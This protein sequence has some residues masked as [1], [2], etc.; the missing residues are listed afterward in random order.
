MQRTSARKGTLIIGLGAVALA[1]LVTIASFLG[2]GQSSPRPTPDPTTAATPVATPQVLSDHLAF[3]R[4][5]PGGFR[6]EFV[7]HEDGQLEVRQLGVGFPDWR[8]DVDARVAIHMTDEDGHLLFAPALTCTD[9]DRQAEM[10]ERPDSIPDLPAGRYDATLTVEQL[11]DADESVR[12]TLEL[13]GTSVL[14][15]DRRAS[16]GWSQAACEKVRT[17]T[18]LDEAT[19]ATLLALIPDQI[20]VM[21]E[22]LT[23]ERTVVDLSTAD[24]STLP[25]GADFSGV[26][27]V[28]G[29][30]PGGFA[31]VT[32]DAYLLFDT[33]LSSDKLHNAVVAAI[34]RSPDCERL[35]AGGAFVEVQCADDY[36]ND[37]TIAVVA[38]ADALL[39]ISWPGRP[40][41]ISEIATKLYAMG[42]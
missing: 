10:R 22:T 33:A 40:E 9:A 7:I 27:A 30:A 6:A 24:T 15:A 23:F 39:V 41:G 36:G 8:Y 12:A 21:G 32:I 42:Q 1:L 2:Y 5:L 17:G 20:D 25:D 28:H 35:P 11:R 18:E 34:E 37:N 29:I 13:V 19:K 31:P 26:A 4:D 16:I 14:N 38:R 3:E